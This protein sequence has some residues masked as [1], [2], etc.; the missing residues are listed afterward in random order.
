MSNTQRPNLNP[1]RQRE[2]SR[3]EIQPAP[4]PA[5]ASTGVTNGNDAL[6]SLTQRMFGGFA[7]LLLFGSA[8]MGFMGTGGM[9][10]S[11]VLGVL[12]LAVAVVTVAPLPSVA[13]TVGWVLLGLI[14]AAIAAAVLVLDQIAPMA[15]ALAIGGG[16]A[17]LFAGFSGIIL[18]VI[19]K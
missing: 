14:V 19:L 10:L 3:A 17:A 13:R 18:K 9:I 8:I 12:A 15:G 1:L 7:C 5:H 4:T 2:S 16:L 11:G 6:I